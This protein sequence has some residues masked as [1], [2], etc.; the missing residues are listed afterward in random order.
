MKK[1][2][3]QEA[4]LQKK[5]SQSKLS[6]NK[7]SQKTLLRK[8]L[9]E[10][11]KSFA[12][13]KQ[14]L[15]AKRLGLKLADCGFFTKRAKLAFYLASDGEINTFPAI[16]KALRETCK[17][18]IPAVEENNG[19][20]FRRFNLFSP[21]IKNQFGIG[22]PRTESIPAIELDIIFLPLV[23]FDKRGNRLGMG[24]GYYDR[25]LEA[26]E[27]NK[28]RPLFIGLAYDEQEVNSIERDTWDIRLDCI[29]TERGAIIC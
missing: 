17:I 3:N 27:G 29:V 16:K 23:G 10:L 8:N 2:E 24:G 4:F 11:R 20:I 19:L 9:R 18:F 14:L 22:E 13:T 12:P 1:S 25:A 7:L 6:Q 21:L 28:R 15:A 26:L 5:L